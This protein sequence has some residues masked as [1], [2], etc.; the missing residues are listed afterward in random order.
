MILKTKKKLIKENSIDAKELIKNKNKF[1][2]EE[3]K[4]LIK[5][6]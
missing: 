3:F 4:T 1:S 6:T 5:R 2:K